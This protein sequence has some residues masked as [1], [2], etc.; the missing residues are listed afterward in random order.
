[1]GAP[2]YD[3]FAI[4]FGLP[5]VLLMGIGPVVAW[6]R[7]SLRALGSQ[8]AVP[9]AVAVAC[10]AALAATGSGSS[11]AGLVG[12]TFAAFVLAAIA[13]EFV[14]GTR[15]RK[16]LG[17]PSWGAALLSLVARNRRRYGGYI[18]HAAIALLVIGAVGIGAFH[19]SREDRL[20]VGERIA[21]GGYTLT[22]VDVVDRRVENREELRAQLH[23][24]RDG[25]SLGILEAGKNRY[26]AEAEQPTNEV[27][28]RTD[29]LRAE[30]LFVIG[31]QFNADGTVDLEVRVNP[32]VNLIWLAGFV[33]LLG[34]LVT[35]WPDAREQRRLARRFAVAGA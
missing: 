12:Y 10:G 19:E 23:V 17:E 35:M 13:L 30:D 3:F 32:L 18:V 29:W 7:S 26:F 33:F 24:V 21:V 31:N 11:A 1:V 15:A 22:L 9:A 5:L 28:I 4:A 14:R 2:Y 6:R 8:L 34:S 20:A 16:A 27:G 25:D